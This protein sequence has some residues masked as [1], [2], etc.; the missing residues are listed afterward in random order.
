MNNKTLMSSL[1][2][3]PE[4]LVNLIAQNSEFR[5]EQ[6]HF[7][8]TYYEGIGK[9]HKKSEAILALAA[10]AILGKKYQYCQDLLK[11]FSPGSSPA[12]NY[13]FYFLSGLLHEKQNQPTSALEAYHKARLEKSDNLKDPCILLKRM[14][15][16]FIFTRKYL[17]A[18]E[19]FPE[20]SNFP[21][22]WQ[23]PLCS[24]LGF[25]SEMLSMPEKALIWYSKTSSDDAASKACQVW[26]E[27]LAGKDVLDQLLKYRG[28]VTDENQVLACDWDFL[29]SLYYLSKDD[30]E[31]ALNLLKKITEIVKKDVYFSSLGVVFYKKKK[32][33]HSFVCFIKALKINQKV[34]ENWFNLA[35][36]YNKV[37]QGESEKAMEKARKIDQGVTFLRDLD[38]AS[39]MILIKMNFSE[40][41]LF[42][43]ESEKIVKRV[44]KE[45]N[46]GQFKEQV[47]EIV[48]P[49]VNPFYATASSGFQMAQGY[50]QF[51][52][53]F[54]RL[55]NPEV[56]QRFPMMPSFNFFANRTSVPPESKPD[57]NLPKKRGR[58]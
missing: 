28:Q 53:S 50:H 44:R 23:T 55:W 54:M 11:T 21:A 34:A 27:H 33:V 17:E 12:L 39:E 58:K 38:A 47:H 5:E 13:L 18:V 16:C 48:A 7:H 8:M 41:G 37:N 3:E 19:Y 4:D 1:Y 45:V 22:E 36:I 46:E 35:V 15:D 25:C 2:L 29:I 49:I 32:I 31:K 6:L 14:L 24:R 57:L 9:I 20:D 56:M 40:F 42:N 52:D 51:Y 10:C 30:L 43:S 26:A